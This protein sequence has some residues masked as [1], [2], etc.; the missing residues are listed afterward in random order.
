M[1]SVG[2][3]QINMIVM[4]V[5]ALIQISQ[6]N[7][8]IRD[9]IFYIMCAQLLF[10]A[11]FKSPEYGVDSSA[12]TAWFLQWREMSLLDVLKYY[13]TEPGYIAINK[14]IGFFTDDI[15]IFYGILAV[16]TLIPQFIFIKK[17][18]MLTGLSLVIFTALGFHEFSMSILRQALA[19]AIYVWGFKYISE[20]KFWKYALF[21]FLAFCFHKTAAITIFLYFLYPWKSTFS[22]LLASFGVSLALF[23]FS[24]WI[25]SLLN[26]WAG[27]SYELNYVAGRNLYILLW[28]LTGGI[29]LIGKKRIN[30]ESI[31]V[32]YDSLNMAAVF[33]SL[34]MAMDTFARAI[35]YYQM[36]LIILISDVVYHIGLKEK[37][38]QRFFVP[39]YF[40]LCVVFYFYYITAGFDST[41]TYSFY[42]LY[43][44]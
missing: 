3:L 26:Q 29:F 31:K 32:H 1:C 38:N 22:R 13:G 40:V 16:I 11:I 41:R 12:Y 28:F 4:M 35:Q 19:L 42:W 7:K 8:K 9:A 39:I 20:R 17:Y 30:N 44:F 25:L 5:E 43:N 23:L 37:K 33:Q 10:L 14:I 18:S 36:S 6:K 2:I 24:P 27:K 21:V 15:V 34:S